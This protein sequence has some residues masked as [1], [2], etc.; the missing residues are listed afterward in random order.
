MTYNV[1]TFFVVSFVSVFLLVS[2]LSPPII[3]LSAITFA[4]PISSTPVYTSPEPVVIHKQ[5][6]ATDSAAATYPPLKYVIVLLQ[7]PLVRLDVKFAELGQ[8]FVSRKSR[9]LALESFQSAAVSTE[10]TL[11]F[12]AT[13]LLT[14]LANVPAAS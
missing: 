7:K 9:I 8:T 4:A 11:C 1:S 6:S 5:Y 10:A 3:P 14:A 12:G 13:T 2:F